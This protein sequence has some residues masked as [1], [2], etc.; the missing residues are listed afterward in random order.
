[1]NHFEKQLE[2][3]P[4]FQ[5]LPHEDLDLI[6]GCCSNQVF[7]PGEMIGREGEPANHFFLIREGQAHIQIFIPNQGEVTI[8]TVGPGDIIG[9]SWLFPP[10]KWSFDVKSVDTTRTIAMDGRCLRKKCDE[11]PAFG[12]PMMKKFAQVMIQRL[13]AA[14]IQVLDI[15][16]TQPP[17]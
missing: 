1:V 3:H 8:Q 11:N 16:Q 10:Y 5:D 14:R 13:K 4:F 9:W 15:Y 2:K 6:A 17:A 12:Y 7:K